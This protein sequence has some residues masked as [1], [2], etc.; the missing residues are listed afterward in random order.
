MLQAL[1]NLRSLEGRRVVVSLTDGSDCGAC[2]LLPV[3]N[4]FGG[5]FGQWTV[6]KTSSFIWP[7]PWTRYQNPRVLENRRHKASPPYRTS[8]DCEG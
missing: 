2:Q 1:T 6:V 7:T 3:T 8:P 4:G 5:A